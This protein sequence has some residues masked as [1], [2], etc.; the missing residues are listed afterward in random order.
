MNQLISELKA[1]L[2]YYPGIM[3]C[4]HIEGEKSFRFS[5]G[6][7]DTNILIHLGIFEGEETRFIIRI[8]DKPEVNNGFAKL[9]SKLR[10][11]ETVADITE[12]GE[13][14]LVFNYG[15]KHNLKSII[16]TLTKDIGRVLYIFNE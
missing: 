8:K 3:S 12:M 9:K 16:N 14:N 11:I 7:K 10:E 6:Y 15:S 2:P 4:H 1:Q 13:R 5:T